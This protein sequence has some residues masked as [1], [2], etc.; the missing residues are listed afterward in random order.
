[1]AAEEKRLMVIDDDQ[2]IRDIVRDIFEHDDYTVRCLADVDDIFSEIN[3]FRPDVLLI[4]YRLGISNGADICYQ[5]KSNAGTLHIPVVLFSAHH[6]EIDNIGNYG[7]NAFI[8]KPFDI[9]HIRRVIGKC[10]KNKP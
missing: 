8:G 10:V 9:D 6:R 7:W 5:I 3:H 2:D 1:M 4:D